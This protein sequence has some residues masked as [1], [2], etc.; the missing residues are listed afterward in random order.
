MKFIKGNDRTQ[1]PIFVSS[2][3]EAISQDN[4]V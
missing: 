2:L 4:E 3:D 1:I